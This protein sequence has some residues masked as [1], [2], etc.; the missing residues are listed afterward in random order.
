MPT[1]NSWVYK[2]KPIKITAEF[3]ITPEDYK[4]SYKQR[5]KGLEAPSSL[6]EYHDFVSRVLYLKFGVHA[7]WRKIKNKTITFPDGTNISCLK[8]SCCDYT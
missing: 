1:K 2:M 8:I 5:N 4:E 7:S 6:K 3:W